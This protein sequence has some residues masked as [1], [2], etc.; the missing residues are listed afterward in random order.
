MNPGRGEIGARLRTRLRGAAPLILDGANGT[1]LERRGVHTGLP[2][3]SSHA[4]LDAPEVVLAI[5]AD[6]ARAGAEI[7]TANTFRTQRRV[8]ERAGIAG[9]AAELTERAVALARAGATERV[10]NGPALVAGSAPTLEDCY[11]PD[12]VPD[13]ASLAREHAAHAANLAA[14][15]VDLVLVETMNTIREAR[16]AARAV[17]E[18]GLP[19]VVSFVCWNGAA[20]LSGELLEAALEAVACEAPLAVGVNCLPPSNVPACLPV[21]AGAGLPTAV[22]ANLGEPDDATGFARSEDCTPDAFAALAATW[23]DAGVQI[24]GGCCGTTPDHLRTLASRL[25]GG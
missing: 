5:H 24:I 9:R 20:L 21:L 3:W 4:L 1:E 12:L 8:L 15:G 22:Y 19:A 14:A 25:R 10:E 17:R 2:L 11:R 13:D 6:Y 16:V 23:R 7:L 18:A